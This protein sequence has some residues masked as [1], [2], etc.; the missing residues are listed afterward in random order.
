MNVIILAFFEEY[1]KERKKIDAIEKAK[2]YSEIEIAA[3]KG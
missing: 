1:L 3:N 2:T